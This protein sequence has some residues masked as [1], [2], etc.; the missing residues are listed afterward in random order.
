[1]D[2]T[3]LPEA[4]ESKP[5]SFNWH[6]SREDLLSMPEE[7]RAVYLN[8]KSS[9]LYEALTMISRSEGARVSRADIE[10]IL[11]PEEMK[12]RHQSLDDVSSR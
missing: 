4:P 5:D 1:M 2:E 8:E 7:D 12:D 6:L 3:T 10:Y 11:N 9:R